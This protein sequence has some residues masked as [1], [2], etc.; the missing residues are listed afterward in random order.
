MRKWFGIIDGRGVACQ[1]DPDAHFDVESLATVVDDAIQLMELI[2][3]R[4]EI[5]QRSEIAV[6]FGGDRPP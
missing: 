1:T 5:A 6:L 2:A 4:A 3:R